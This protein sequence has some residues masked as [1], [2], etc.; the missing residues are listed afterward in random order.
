MS[1][2]QSVHDSLAAR[3]AYDREQYSATM[4]DQSARRAEFL[5]LANQVRKL[6]TTSAEYQYYAAR[7]VDDLEANI[8]FFS[9]VLEDLDP[10]T[11]IE[12]TSEPDENPIDP[13]EAYG[14]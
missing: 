13:Y 4:R 11:E 2:S 8:K 7:L 6:C 5:R 10:T 3:R 9:R 14:L 12:F 1:I